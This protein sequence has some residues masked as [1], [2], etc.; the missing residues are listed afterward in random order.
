MRSLGACLCRFPMSLFDIFERE[1]LESL[2]F[3]AV[4]RKSPSKFARDEKEKCETSHAIHS[5]Y[6]YLPVYLALYV[7]AYIHIY[8]Y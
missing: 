3:G 2:Q 4:A 6:S 1:D 5:I 7:S 8:T